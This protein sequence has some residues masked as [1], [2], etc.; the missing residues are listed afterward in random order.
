MFDL[1]ITN[2]R[3]IDG[4]GAPWFRAHVGVRDG[5]IADVFCGAPA[6]AETVIDAG[7][8]FL[9]PGFIDVHTHDDIAFLR[10]GGRGEK[11]VQGVTTIV[12][13]N[14]SFSAYPFVGDDDAP[15]RE[16]IGSLLGSIRPGEVFCDYAGYRA[17][18]QGGGIGP[19]LVS[20]VGHGP[21]RLAVL[22]NQS[23]PATPE[24]RERMERLLDVQLEQGAAGLSLGLI[25][26]PSSWADDA[27]LRG[28]AD[29]VAKRGRILAAHIRNYDAGIDESIEEFL[30]LLKHSGCKGLLSHLQVCGSENW[31]RMPELLDRLEEARREGIDVS[32]DMYPYTAG[33]STI[34]QLLPPSAQEGGIDAIVDRLSEPESREIIRQAVVEDITA[35]L[36]WR[37][38]ATQI[39]W[40][41]IRIGG[42]EAESHK[43]YEGR[44]IAEAAESESRDPFDLAADLIVCDCGRSNMIM[45]QQDEG[46][47]RKVL[48]HRLYMSGSDSIPRE[49]GKPHPRG[50]GTFPRLLGEY[51]LKDNLQSLEEAVRHMTSLPAQRFSLWDRGV[52][53]PGAVADLVLFG[54][55]VIDGATYDEPTLPPK[56]IGTVI[57]GGKLVVVDGTPQSEMPGK[58]LDA[59]KRMSLA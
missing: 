6:D 59:G 13:G 54:A 26:T 7:D 19:N 45:F 49:S 20:L 23:R 58:V 4:T 52:V 39:G 12:T 8:A 40:D 5:R 18:L 25:Y 38:K 31:G 48:G 37:S 30:A 2:A 53:R 32:C 1:L 41:N 17:A 15:L 47:L 21:I 36:N 16:H 29:V 46:D 34:L 28:L 11:I 51:A 9:T 50:A 55:T 22:G 33:S 43:R 57:V 42:V 24:E 44:F 14:C 35:D 56:G 3:V 10:R 27:E